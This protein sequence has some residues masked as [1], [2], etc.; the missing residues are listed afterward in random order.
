MNKVKIRVLNTILAVA[1]ALRNYS[2]PIMK[3]RLGTHIIEFI[4][5]RMSNGCN[6][7]DSNPPFLHLE[8]KFGIT[9]LKC[10]Y[11]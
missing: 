7:F 10:N 5:G 2:G 9:S 8:H 3:L 11:I 4:F 1:F 6:G